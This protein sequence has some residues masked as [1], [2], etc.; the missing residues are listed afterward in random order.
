MEL[1]KR[2]VWALW[3]FTVDYVF[4]DVSQGQVFSPPSL[5]PSLGVNASDLTATPIL[6]LSISVHDTCDG[7]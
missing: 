4:V 6:P 1:G 5:P 2:Y 7:S 3:G